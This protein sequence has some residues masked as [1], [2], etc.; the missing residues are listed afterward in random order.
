ME[1]PVLAKYNALTTNINNDS[2]V[3]TVKHADKS[4]LDAYA[5]YYKEK[6]F[7]VFENRSIGESL[8]IALKR[9]EEGIFLNYYGVISTLTAVYEKDSSY[10]EFS[11]PAGDA[12][13][14]PQISQ[15]HL[16]DF[17]MSYAIRLSDGRFIIFDGGREFE[18]DA[19]RLYKCL[20]AGSPD[21]KPVIAAWIMTHPHSD[22]FHC[23]VKFFDMYSSEVIIERFMYTFPEHDD[24][25]HYPAMTNTDRRFD[26][27]TS[28]DVF[29]PMMQERI[30]ASGAKVY[31]PHTG[32]RY[33]IGDA[34]C[35]ILA[36]IDDTIFNTKNINATSLVIRME[37]GGQVILWG[38]DAT[39]SE[40]DLP[41]K[42]G[43]FLKS[44]ILQIP[45]H[46]FQS[47][48]AEAEIKGYKLIAP[49]VCLLPV[50][51]FNAF[52]VMG[53]YREATRFLMTDAGVEEIIAGDLTRTLTLP[54]KAD[55]GAKNVLRRKYLRGRAN[56]GSTTWV[57]TNLST[58][59]EEDFEF[60]LLNMT[61]YAAKV[62]I[63]LFFENSSYDLRYIETE[64]PRI[65]IKTLSI[66]GPD[67]NGD[68]RYFNWMSLKELGV[69][70]NESFA[71]RFIADKPIV[72]SHKNHAPAYVSPISE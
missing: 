20:K 38:A 6:G 9:G 10:F 62:E 34:V 23:F 31:S 67:V 18:P 24:V 36:S 42:Y 27:N 35:D 32:Q 19:E 65:S 60:T 44:D 50:S 25:E 22:H 33:V 17:G 52:T 43:D 15:I 59:T 29:I 49:S 1:F 68:A 39:F 11:A 14:T 47:G 8:C 55:S 54:Y 21:E 5:T 71:V 16:E 2:D 56:A 41:E 7:E 13:V 3:V 26:Y 57:F 12:I 4:V 40:I 28:P 66:I 46:G 51:E 64:S 45:H 70:D 61:S 37:L 63:E 48:T 72:V 30:E 58:A 53:T 69:P